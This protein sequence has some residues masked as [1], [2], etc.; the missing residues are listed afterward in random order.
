MG[1]TEASV[2]S[3]RNHHRL[4]PLPRVPLI[5]WT[6]LW[7]PERWLEMTFIT[8]LI[9]IAL[10]FHYWTTTSITAK[11]YYATIFSIYFAGLGGFLFLFR[12]EYRRLPL[13][14]LIPLL[15]YI[16]Y[17]TIRT[18]GSPYPER[19]WESWRTTLG[20]ISPIL[21]AYLLI[22]NARAAH[23]LLWA[24]TIIVWAVCGYALVQS[25]A[26]NLDSFMGWGGNLDP[27]RWPWNKAPLIGSLL[28]FLETDLKLFQWQDF[29]AG[30]PLR[31]VCSTFGNP[32]FLAGF[33][34]MLP[35]LFFASAICR[36]SHG[37]R[38]WPVLLTLIMVFLAMGTTI[39]KGAVL[40][41]L[42][43]V[44]IFLLFAG[45]FTESLFQRWLRIAFRVFGFALLIVTFV[46]VGGALI[47]V[48]A[49]DQDLHQSLKSV[50]SRTITYQTT[51][52]LVRNNWL[53]GVSPGNFT[54][55]FPD[56]LEGEL[57]EE[58]GWSESPEEKVMEHAHCEFLEIWADL[59]LIGLSLFLIF[60][61]MS[62]IWIWKAWRAS[63]GS[64][65]GWMLAGM[66]SG[67]FGAFCENITSVSLRW[68]PSAWAFWALLGGCLGLAVRILSHTGLLPLAI[69][70][71]FRSFRGAMLQAVTA[72]LTLLLFIP[73][74]QRFTADWYF[75]IGRA[76]LTGKQN[77]AEKPLLRSAE[78][79]PIQPATHYLLGG[80]FFEVG[81]YRKAVEHF[82]KVRDLR[83]DVVVIA[84]NL[85]TAYFKIS[86]IGPTE[87]E[88]QEALLKAIDLYEESLSRHPT[89]ARL[90]DYLARSYQRIG[91]ERLAKE[92]RLKA[93]ALYEK[94]FKWGK[95]YPRPDYAL[96][97][98]KNYM[99]EKE[100]Q[101][102]FS[103][104]E[105][106]YRWNLDSAKLNPALEQLFQ[107][108]PSLRERWEATVKKWDT[109]RMR[110][111][112][113]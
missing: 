5:R 36:R 62:A 6:Q 99:V 61:I 87:A 18:I 10:V 28:A 64:P 65:D 12:G 54:V 42:G 91:L 90:E 53:L 1:N 27:V 23:R 105:N 2:T 96:D 88:R 48:A 24:S 52:S 31:R 32:T 74:S 17:G 89:F 49:T 56:Y 15:L 38:L 95:S 78:L 106:A 73:S 21:P 60:L 25:V 108:D 79:N 30:G 9:L 85:A 19:A 71:A 81:N 44:A 70:R 80:H 35:T 46:S 107:D 69:P 20:F 109:D 76:A 39:S 67:V 47:F 92:H 75:T 93:I 68:T 7:N 34:V 77:G 104:L 83:G 57:A 111:L 102:A 43:G 84:E 29:P 3:V 66:A 4:E 33:L 40:G 103:I 11:D 51:W 37:K 26:E 16:V 94:W 59:G 110:K 13:G 86:T 41:T 82:Q 72:G 100:Y 58:Y 112:L 45:W 22:Q 63:G 113:K 101:K 50:Q 14:I 55:F 98:G 8:A 97:L